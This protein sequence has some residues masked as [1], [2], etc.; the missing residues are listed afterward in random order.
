MKISLF[1]EI[2]VARPWDDDT[3]HRR[4][5]EYLEVAELADKVGFNTLWVT[6]H[7]FLDEYCH[8][9]APD[10]FLATVAGR[11]KNLRL[12][13]GII[14]M[15]PAINHPIHV[16]ERVSTLDIMSNGRVEFGTGEGNAAAELD[17]FDV[18]GP[19]KQDMWREGVKVATR[20]MYETPFTGFHGEF[21]DLPPRNVVPKPLQKPHPPVWVACTKKGK[22]QLA[23]ESGIG[24]LNFT[25]AGPDACAELVQ[26]Y[27]GLFENA[28]PIVPEPNPN[29]LFLPG[30]LSCAPTRE[31]AVERI[32]WT[33]NWFNFVA[34]HRLTQRHY[35]GRT[36]LWE[37]YGQIQRG[38]VPPLSLDPDAPPVAPEEWPALAAQT[39]ASE[40]ARIPSVGTPAEILEKLLGYE[41]AGCDEMMFI[42]PMIRHEWIMES[43]ELIGKH[44]IPVM[45]ERHEKIAAE[46][47]ERLAPI[48]EKVRSRFV[49]DGPP[50]DPEYSHGGPAKGITGV[51]ELMKAG[52]E[53]RARLHA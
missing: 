13:H 5:H 41:A 48:M 44:I 22:V 30:S 35:P 40:V 16:A 15:P 28:V 37:L 3:E 6:E 53:A 47:A 39:N 32:G 4:F 31:Q 42:L 21:V 38:E 43:I 52:H 18:D 24:A 27:Y 29:M 51:V 50:Y 19:R 45:H 23:A 1:F 10:V 2:G 14:Q 25:W 33:A 12:G 20:A 46:K 11:T 26:Y 17:P 34:E 49:N 7:H 36:D 9:S 8:A